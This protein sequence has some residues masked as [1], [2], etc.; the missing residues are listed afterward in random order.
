M[1][2]PSNLDRRPSRPSARRCARLRPARRAPAEQFANWLP[3]SAYLA[4]KI[5]VNRD[6]MGV[7]LELMPQSGA[8]ERM[9]EVLVSLYANCPP[10]TGIQ[11]HLFGSAPGAQP[12]CATT[13]TC[14]SRTPIRPSRPRQWAARPATGTCSGSSP[15]SASA[16]CCRARR[17][18]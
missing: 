9:A 6:S 12:S 2:A 3:Y 16:T 13:P 18:R 11:F 5:F 8:D 7:M 15:A 1:N 14:G 10:G 17:S 4:P